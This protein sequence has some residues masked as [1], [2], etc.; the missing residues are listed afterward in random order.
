M[1][2][3]WLWT[4]FLAFG[5]QPSFEVA[6]VRPNKSGGPRYSINPK[7]DRFTATNISVFSLLQWA[8]DVEAFRI[9]G[10]P[11]WFGSD[12]FDVEGKA[13]GVPSMAQF[14][15]MLQ[16]LLA[17]QFRLKLHRDTKQGPVYELVVARG[18]PKLKPAKCVG[19]PSPG[20]PCGGFTG[21]PRGSLMGRADT[22][23]EFAKQLSAILDRPVVNKTGLGDAYDFDLIWTPDEIARQGPGDPDAPAVDP[24]GPSFFTAV[25]EQ[26]GLRLLSAKGP[27]DFLV[28][29]SVARPAP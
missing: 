4:A 13:E 29:D 21:S 15:L 23:P 17:D 26:L 25:E 27:V 24:A 28:I 11:S 7:G 6:S 22:L 18:G 20:N 14:R 10:A 8:Y 5:Q 1:K 9:S 19:T 3:L 16:P 12:R 2:Q